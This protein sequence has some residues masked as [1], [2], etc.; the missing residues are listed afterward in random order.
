LL[1]C[2]AA[3]Q[4]APVSGQGIWE[5]TLQARDLNGDGVTDAFYDTE[6]NV[7]WL[8]NADLNG[9]M[10]WFDAANWANHLVVGGYSGWRLPT[11]LDTGAVGCDFSASG[12]TD[13]G[14]N[15]QTKS[16]SIV[17][18]ELA[19]LYYKTL[20]NKGQ[21][22]AGTG[23]PQTGY[24]L[25]NTGLFEN[26]P[27]EYGFYATSLQY[28]PGASDWD[29][30]YG[31]PGRDVWSF[32]VNV[33]VQYHYYCC[34]TRFSAIAVHPGDVAAAI[35]EPETYALMLAGLTALAVVQRRRAV[36]ASAF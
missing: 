23:L 3:A 22:A 16:G 28:V 5:T 17:Y 6:L 33:G 34:E 13:C 11:M 26:F 24:G 29:P 8:R 7:T 31:P 15:V 21:Y 32:A 19:H 4:A 25:S 18:S 27:I 1:L 30:V 12:G 9:L 35:P 2:G 10:S 14:Y 20:G 36:G